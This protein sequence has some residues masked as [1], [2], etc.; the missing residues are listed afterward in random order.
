MKKYWSPHFS[1]VEK[2]LN[3]R[4]LCKSSDNPNGDEVLTLNHFLFQRGKGE[5]CFCMDQYRSKSGR[6]TSGE[7]QVASEDS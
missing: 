1:E 5:H 7:E 6:T 3:I 2:V 4:P